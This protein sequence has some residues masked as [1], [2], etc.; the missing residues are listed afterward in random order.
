MENT[1]ASSTEAERHRDLDRFLTFIDAV[2]AIAITLLVLPLV[3]LT[4]DI[5]DEP[6]RHVL[7]EHQTQIWAF[8]LSFL[9]IS[10]L[11]FIQHASVRHVMLF[12][13]RVANLTLLWVLTIVILPFPTALVA[14][15]G[16]DPL[17]KVLYI[18]TIAVGV[19]A[20]ALSD[21]VVQRHPEITD[22]QGLPDAV[23]AGVNVVLLLVALALTLAVPSLGYYPLLL[24]AL[25][26][27]VLRLVAAA[28]R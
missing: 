12:H 10:R 1:G 15:A 3:E 17:V 28:R 11:W 19:L 4:G 16:H 14:T 5:G 22:G 27:T 24:L 2:V 9:V 18:G 21:V 23:N 26:T 8:F 20:L 7:D 6:V 25:D 13:P